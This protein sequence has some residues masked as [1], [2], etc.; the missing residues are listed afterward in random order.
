MPGR[1]S[2]TIAPSID[3]HEAHI[4]RLLPCARVCL[5]TLGGRSD[6]VVTIARVSAWLTS[7]T[8]PRDGQTA[9]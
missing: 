6:L 2:S 4:G 8:I 1:M 3:T 5:P 9:W 7:G